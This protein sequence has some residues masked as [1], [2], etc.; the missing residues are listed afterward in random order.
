VEI[1]RAFVIQQGGTGRT[2]AITSDNNDGWGCV[3]SLSGNDWVYGGGGIV[4]KVDWRCPC[5][6]VNTLIPDGKGC[7]GTYIK[8][9]DGKVVV[10]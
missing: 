10:L 6:W 3:P 8:F 5:T 2:H 7:V 4:Q 1:K 9:D